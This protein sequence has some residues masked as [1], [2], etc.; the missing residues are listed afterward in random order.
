MFSSPLSPTV[1]EEP[2]IRN[3]YLMIANSSQPPNNVCGIF[4]FL[5]WLYVIWP[6]AVCV[7]LYCFCAPCE[8]HF[9]AL[10]WSGT[11]R[12]HIVVS[13]YLAYLCYLYLCGSGSLCWFSVP[14]LMHTEATN[15]CGDYTV[16][17]NPAGAPVWILYLYNY[18][19]CFYLVSVAHIQVR[20][21]VRK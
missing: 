20:S 13:V 18:Y 7:T 9:V 10:C 15:R 11:D 6:W 17:Q 4:I 12:C 8:S 21:I 16:W 14:H 1:Q 2:E 3:C 19:F 5:F